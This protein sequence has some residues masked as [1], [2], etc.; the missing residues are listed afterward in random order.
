M[1][2]NRLL[3]KGEF[4]SQTVY[5][6]ARDRQGFIW[7]GTRRC[8]V[9][10][11]GQSFRNFLFPE[12]YLIN[13]M[14]ADSAN[15][16]W[17]ASDRRGICRIDPHTFRLTS[18]PGIPKTTGYFFKSS[19]GDG[20]FATANGVGR[21]NLR[22]RQVALYPFRQTT[23]HGLKAKG[24]LED[25]HHRLWVIGSDNGIFRFDSRT[26]RF[27]CVLG[28]DCPDPA[29]Q[30]QL[31]LGRGCVDANGILWIGAYGHGLL[32]IDPNTEQFS[33]FKVP[34][35]PNRITCVEE[36]QD[37]H[38]Q[39]VLWVGDENGLLVF[40]PEQRQ[41]FRLTTLQSAPFQ[42]NVLYRDPVN[43]ILWVGTS[44][45]VFSYNPQ[46]NLIQTVALPPSLVRQPVVVKV[47]A[48]D[49]QDTTGQT[50]WLGLSHTG[51][52][53]WHRPTNR[54]SLIRFPHGESEAMW[55][56]QTNAN[57]LWIGLR[58]WSYKGDGVL[59]YDTRANRFVD[60]PAG[61]RAGAL[62]S[63]PFVDH[64][65]I[66][67]Q[68]RLWV[69]N[70]DEGLHALALRTGK[71]L[72]Y[73]SDSVRSA[74]HRN[75]NFLTG[76]AIDT[77][78]RIWL[79]TY[80]GLYYVAEPGHRFVW[81]DGGQANT[82]L[83]DDLA[84]NTILVARNGHVWAARWG[85]VTESLPDGRL[86]TVLTARNGLYDREN[87]RLAEDKEGTIWIGNFDGLHSYNPTNK[88]FL[89]LTTNDGLSHNTT[90]AALYVHR[91]TELFI[92]QQNGIDHFD[93]TQLH[94]R[95]VIPPV[96]VTAFHVQEQER[97][98]DPARP[99]QLAR[100]DNAF[101]VDF[102]TLRYSR[103]ANT[104][105]AY[106]LEGLDKRW[107]YSGALHRAY[108]TNLDPGQY[109][110]H[111]NATDS[112]GNWSQKPLLLSIEIRPAYYETWWFRGLVVLLV[113]GL[114]Y[115][116]YRYR[117]NQ[118]MR[119]LH[120]RNRISADLHD[121]IGSSLS[122]I[123]ILGTIVKQNLPAEHPS[124]SMVERIVSEARH[125]SNSL[126]DI[127]W[128]INPNNDEL[129]SLIARMNRYAA[130]LF[131]A[132]GIAYQISVPDTIQNLTLP[133]EKRQDLYLISK[134]A[135]NNLVKHA[136][137]TEASLKISL[138]HQ[139]LYLE[140]RDNGVGFDLNAETERNGVR[141]MLTRAKNLHGELT[142]TSVAGQGT[143]LKL[144]FPV[145][146]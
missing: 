100:T 114:L 64:G 46:D 57:Q 47:I 52:L 85:S 73:W 109:T 9:R 92:G 4:P 42:T 131:E 70:N 125:V 33:F 1:V 27:V 137:A 77:T 55:F 34:H 3:D 80:R 122:G 28:L 68:Q 82:R 74:L 59:V 129:S 12:T 115:G 143:S 130:E 142:I 104:Q 116:L 60:T 10:Y 20:W 119:V 69:G 83:L 88:R 84:T 14:A 93:V 101:S 79:A 45:G 65:L 118:L 126:D 90:T 96:V 23:Y 35:E 105:Y 81:A 38:G 56:Q 117:I 18:I 26:N 123:G 108:Y 43:G 124:G 17:V 15:G 48:A 49:R 19:A 61:K 62:F 11:D 16:M 127:V 8:P 32:R 39:R 75:N 50:F 135:V 139:R 146:L 51:I 29:R 138:E 134:E 103:L 132:S 120:I 110:L 113:A 36:G 66:D 133:M 2:F 121:E 78:D 22:T 13:G 63:V 25:K 24:F 37:E 30:K 89:R 44:R 128:S 95:T 97:P 112:F 76:L 21:I 6:I 98:F 91:G 58:E 53:R 140:V 144:S 67:N 111:L 145:S 54:F 99:I 106:F 40:R 5:S 102:T 71:P 41:F 94:R 72:P 107:T 141:N 7:F 86:T 31:Y 136:N 87:R